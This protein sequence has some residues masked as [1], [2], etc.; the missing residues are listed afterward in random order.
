MN[1]EKMK[2]KMIKEVRPSQKV[3]AETTSPRLK[4]GNAGYSQRSGTGSLEGK[5][6][7]LVAVHPGKIH[8]NNERFSGSS[9][10]SS[11]SA[12]EGSRPL[13][14]RLIFSKK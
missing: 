1:A 12:V 3:Q 9:P 7:K 4:K 11:S 5:E 10:G 8:L 14:R 2:G 6:A 13:L